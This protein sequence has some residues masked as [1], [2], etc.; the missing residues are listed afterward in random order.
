MKV[1]PKKCVGCGNCVPVCTMGAIHVNGVAEVNEDECVE[2]GTCRRFLRIEGLNPTFVRLVRAVLAAF[3]L[4]YRAPLDVCPTGALYQP[5]LTWP[6][7]V[8]KSFSDPTTVHAETGIGGR[9]TE[10]IKTNDV[11]GRLGP[12]E[13]GIVVEL[14]RPGLGV[15]FKE[16]QRFSM[17]LAEIGAVFE[18]NN[19]VTHLMTDP[20]TGQLKE[21]VLEE[22]VYSAIIEMKTTVERVP[23]FLSVINRVG[24]SSPT[25]F[26]IAISAKCGPNGEIPYIEAVAEAGY[27]LS[28]NGKT[29]LG[30]GRRAN[31]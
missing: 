11:T 6:R 18:K 9:G 27:E 7:I 5:D 23:E 2:C 14:G 3:R 4:Q 8:R 24:K 25:V 1:D 12:G 19:P 10:E 29:N 28:L 20:N 30:L 17:A 26:G 31:P 13:V 22:K 21:D 15:R 16:L